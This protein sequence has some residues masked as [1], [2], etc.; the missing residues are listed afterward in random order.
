M[1]HFKTNN[2]FQNV[3]TNRPPNGLF[4]L[5]EKVKGT[6]RIGRL[7]P[8]FCKECVPGDSFKINAEL[9]TRMAPMT[10]PVMHDMKAY[11]HFFK[12]P[13]RLVY[14]DWGAWIT[15][16]KNQQEFNGELPY[17]NLA[18]VPNS[19]DHGGV[20]S[21]LHHLGC[22]PF[23]GDTT[24][25]EYVN[26][27]SL[28][29]FNLII[30]EYYI[31]NDLQEAIDIKK[32]GGEIDNEELDLLTRPKMR[33]WEKDRFTSARPW[34]QAGDDVLLPLG[35]SAPVSITST[36][37]ANI[38][39]AGIRR[40]GGGSLDNEIANVQTDG[41]GN[42]LVTEGPGV[43]RNY[44]EIYGSSTVNSTGTGTADLSQATA[45]TI[46][47]LREAFAIQRFFERLA[48]SGH[49]YIEYIKAFFGVNSSDARLQRPEYLGGGASNMMFSEV[50]QNSQSDTTPQGTMAGHGIQVGATNMVNS[51]C[52]EHCYII[53]V[54]SFLPRTGYHQGLPKF[55]SRRDRFEFY[56]PSFAHLGEEPILNKELYWQQIDNNDDNDKVFGYQSRYSDYRS[57]FNRTVGDFT[58]NLDFWHMNR[59]FD[60]L[61]ELNSDFVECN[62]AEEDLTRIF[63][64]QDDTDHLWSMIHVNCIA[65]RPMP[66][67][68]EPGLIDHY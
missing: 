49:R 35:G 20:R 11:M 30:N 54:L 23:T 61:P 46:S 60:S 31:D 5:S 12:V 65:R 62:A 6:Y 13:M 66:F 59:I 19:V 67:D 15:G 29:A 48:R 2:I 33:C 58:G 10:A 57:S 17:F 45:S 51:F 26:A 14:E 8:F 27:M 37:T 18:N 64:V 21:I 3:Q 7:Y 9:M 42:Q 68:A 44:A 24:D 53:G 28:R 56:N 50:L 52:E 55:M 22:P 36:G 1:K 40:L 43:D 41:N 32:T 4:D 38:A 34:P 16:R 25:D 47:D 39:L 63:A